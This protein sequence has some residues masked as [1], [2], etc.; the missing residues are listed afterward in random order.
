M[1]VEATVADDTPKRRGRPRKEAR[2]PAPLEMT[3]AAPRKSARQAQA[4][5]LE[6]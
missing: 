6:G 3:Q 4:K 1:P 2:I 5:E